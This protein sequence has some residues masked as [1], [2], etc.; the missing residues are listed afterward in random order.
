MGIGIRKKHYITYSPKPS[1]AGHGRLIGIAGSGRGTGTTHLCILAANYLTSC[2]QRKTALIQWNSHG[3]FERLGQ[4]LKGFRPKA[5]GQ[6][7]RSGERFRLM[8]TD[9]CLQGEPA[10]LARCMDGTYDDIII[11]FGEL[12]EDIRSEWLRCGTK[13]IAAALNDWKLETFLEFL[14]GEEK[15]DN[16]WIY[17]AA[18]GSEHTR[19]EIERRFHISLLRIPF[20]E[21]AFS[22]DRQAMAWF[23]DILKF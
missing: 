22:V 9:Y 2:L 8:E 10:L 12:R 5:A 17:T 23:E 4:A 13:I 11:D 14:A 1:A 19:L 15:L 6:S 18:F 7:G 20:S 21:D 3:D 16:R